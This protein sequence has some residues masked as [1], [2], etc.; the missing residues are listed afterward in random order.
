MDFK[1]NDIKENTGQNFLHAGTE[2][3]LQ[4]GDY[5]DASQAGN[6]KVVDL[7][8]VN[9]LMKEMDLKHWIRNGGMDM[10]AIHRFLEIYLDNTQHM[11]HYLRLED[12]QQ[13]FIFP[14]VKQ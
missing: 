9:V 13:A 6:D 7:K 2:V 1:K 12:Q 5:I 10:P 14:F 8:P 11:H 3:L 4:L